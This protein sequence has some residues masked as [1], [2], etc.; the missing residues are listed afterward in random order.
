MHVNCSQLHRFYYFTAEN[1][2]RLSRC[3]KG[4]DAIKSELS[5]Y[6]ALPNVLATLKLLFGKPNIIHHSLIVQV[7][8]VPSVKDEK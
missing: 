4:Q 2:E 6:E 7:R 8:S 5:D 1:L 3:L